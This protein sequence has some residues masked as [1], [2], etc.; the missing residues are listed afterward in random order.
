VE[1]HAQRAA[2]EHPGRLAVSGLAQNPGARDGA[3]VGRD[4]APHIAD[5]PPDDADM[6]HL[7]RTRPAPGSEVT[8]VTDT[9]RPGR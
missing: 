1:Q 2:V 8:V 7:D 6:P 5:R 4:P 9:F 3:L